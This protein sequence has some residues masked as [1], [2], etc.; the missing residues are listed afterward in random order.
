[1]SGDPSLVQRTGR[2]SDDCPSLPSG[3]S[4]SAANRAPVVR[5]WLTVLFGYLAFGETLQV[6]PGLTT[7][8]FGAGPLLVGLV[9]GVASLASAALRPVAGRAADAGWARRSVLAAGALGV[10]G[11]LG[12]LWSPNLAVLFG[13]RLLLGASEGALF[14][15]AVSWILRLT[16]LKRRGNIAGWFGL[17]MWGGLALGPV[18]AVGLEHLGGL[19]AVWAAVIGL[20]AVGFALTLTTRPAAKPAAR[21]AGP[22]ALLPAPARLPGVVLGL[23]SY[24]Y[25][26]I[27]SL[28]L[29]RL[30]DGDLG[31]QSIALAIFAAAFVITRAAGSPLVNWLGGPPI[32][33]ASSLV[34]ALGLALIGLANSMTLAVAGIVICGVG[35]AMLYPATVAIA[36]ERVPPNQ[37]GAAVGAMTSL[38]DLAIVAAGPIGG[39]IVH[40]AG[41]PAAFGLA[42]GTSVTA[43]LMVAAIPGNE[44]RVWH[45]APGKD[46]VRSGLLPRVPAGQA[47]G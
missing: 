32:A 23:A 16:S 10:L 21:V 47:A 46:A 14:V 7:S 45:D 42:A 28:L 1:M 5:L 9:I 20:P 27:V 41:Y 30:R 22:R 19:D 43:A 2:R 31:G 15:A 33:A 34:E 17:S 35:T 25:G 37:H 38:W 11:G 39:L 18:L 13:A 24:G 3:P 44:R 8:R 26:T 6:L 4:P 12:H 40:I 36:V 29:L